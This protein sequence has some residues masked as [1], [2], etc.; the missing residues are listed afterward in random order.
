MIQP[1]VKGVRSAQLLDKQ[2][3][4]KT[5][6]LQFRHVREEKIASRDQGDGRYGCRRQQRQYRSVCLPAAA[7]VSS[8]NA[9]NSRCD[10]QLIPV[11]IVNAVEGANNE[12]VTV[13]DSSSKA[14]NSGCSIE[15]LPVY[16]V[17]VMEGTAVGANNSYSPLETLPEQ[18]CE[19]G[20]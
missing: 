10:V 9:E 19:I 2:V 1:S 15:L 5:S 6:W 3:A 16:A 4:T 13:T 14:E 17:D 11:L 12:S 8:S 20:L 7:T 18:H